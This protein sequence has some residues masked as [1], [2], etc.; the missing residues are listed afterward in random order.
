ME[1][2][3]HPKL[4]RC[5]AQLNA[6][7]V[8][9]YPTEAVW[10]LGCDPFNHHAVNRILELK[11]RP[12]DKGLILV[13]AT[14]EQVDWLLSGL[15]SALYQQLQSSWPGHV[16][17]LIPHHGRIPSNVCGLHDTIAIR[18]STHPL[19]RALCERFGGPIVSTSANPQGAPPAR[20]GIAARRYFRKHDVIFTP[21]CV[22]RHRAPSVIRDLVSG[23]IL[24]G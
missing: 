1:Y 19:V 10:G 21:G 16:T 7:G 4:Y 12:A 18:V 14:I 6:G 20:T 22:G 3:Y 13:A 9:A 8:I 15:P 23:K 5:V 24:R 17:W 2:R 11:Q